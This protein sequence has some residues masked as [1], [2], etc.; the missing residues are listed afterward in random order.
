MQKTDRGESIGFQSDS[1]R[2]SSEQQMGFAMKMHWFSRRFSCR[3]GTAIMLCWIIVAPAAIP[4][5][6]ADTYRGKSEEVRESVIAGT[7]YP[8]SPSDLRA[9]IEH[10]LAEVPERQAQ[11]RLIAL[12][13]PHAGYRYSGQ[14]AAHGYKLLQEAKFDSV[15]VLAPSHHMRFSGVSVYDRGGFRTPLG[16]V[17]LDRDMI[18]DLMKREESIRSL[19]EAHG[20]EHSLEIQLPFLQVVL[21]GFKLVP[22]VMGEQDMKTCEKLAEALFQC[23]RGK[24][25]LVVASSDLSHFH[26][27]DE[28]RKLDQKVVERLSAFDPKGLHEKLA[29]G[30]C[31]A[32]GGGPMVTSMLYARKVGADR[33]Q[34]LQYANSGDATGIQN[35]PRGVVGYVSAAFWIA[36]PEK[37]PSSGAEEKVGVDLGLS[38]SEKTLLHQIARE[39][40]EARCRG[41]QPPKR[42]IESA[43]LKELRGAFVTLHKHGKLRGCIGHI[44]GRSPLAETVAEMAVAAA[45]QDPRFPPLDVGELDQ[46]D[47]EISVLTPLE[48]LQNP[49]DIQIGRQGLVMKKG[50]RSGLLLPQVATEQG[51]DRRAF[52]ENAC[53]KAGLP[54]DAWKDG[55]TEI[56]VFSADVF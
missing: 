24:S 51:W 17:P 50:P 42:R 9:Q 23:T 19:P 54:P 3:T 25:A 7:W 52:L 37:Q 34:V 31:E 48:R 20:K 12:V 36:A 18:T 27:Y 45:F 47:I 30:E 53:I 41:T 32:C 38:R 4:A 22:L 6:A 56:Y 16:V 8:S 55:D 2:E 11:G 49:E 26:S 1:S 29:A 33:G 35:D 15:I 21:P 13:A 44:T 10:F 40:I 14:V 43:K 5:L 46:I 28:A 39:S